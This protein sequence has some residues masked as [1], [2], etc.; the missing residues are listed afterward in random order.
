MVPVAPVKKTTFFIYVK[1]IIYLSNNINNN[2][3][4]RCARINTLGRSRGYLL[5]RM[6]ELG[7]FVLGELEGVVDEEHAPV[8]VLLSSRVFYILLGGF[9]CAI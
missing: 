6:K 2:N 8:F 3:Q 9:G 5:L 4:Q 7:E 1:T